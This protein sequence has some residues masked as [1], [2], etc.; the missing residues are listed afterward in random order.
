MEFMGLMWKEMVVFLGLGL[1]LAFGVIV[2]AIETVFL[3][4]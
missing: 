4:D 2:A 1:F 3:K